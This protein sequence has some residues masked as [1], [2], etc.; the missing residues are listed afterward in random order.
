M[1][2]VNKDI[3]QTRAERSPRSAVFEYTELAESR[4]RYRVGSKRRQLYDSLNVI[5][6]EP[7]GL[8]G[9]CTCYRDVRLGRGEVGDLAL[10]ASRV[11]RSTGNQ[12]HLTASCKAS[13]F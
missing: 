11:G 6:K 10:I 8:V 4:T 2:P 7:K 9:N 5:R 13:D 3:V 12:C 1:K